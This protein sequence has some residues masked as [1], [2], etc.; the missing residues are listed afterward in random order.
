MNEKKGTGSDGQLWLAERSAGSGSSGEQD[1][2][3]WQEMLGGRHPGMV[4]DRPGG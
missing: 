3:G 4:S 1:F 2:D